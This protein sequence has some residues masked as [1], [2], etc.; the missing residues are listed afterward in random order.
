MSYYGAPVTA[1][2]EIPQDPISV[3]TQ[4]PAPLPEIKDATVDTV[5]LEG[6]LAKRMPPMPSG[7]LNDLSF[8]NSKQIEAMELMAGMRNAYAISNY[9]DKRS[10][11][12][13]K[14]VARQND[15]AI[16]QSSSSGRTNRRKAQSINNQREKARVKHFARNV[17][18]M[19]AETYR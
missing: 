11:A 19:G 3:F 8:T 12:K 14:A 17:L 1:P 9:Y 16:E 7:D 4:V 13:S 5:R 18:G 2:M 15:K 10:K 6:T